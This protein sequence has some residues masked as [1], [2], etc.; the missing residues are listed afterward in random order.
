MDNI[1]TLRYDKPDFLLSVSYQALNI[2]SKNNGLRR[3]MQIAFRLGT[4]LTV[5]TLIGALLGYS[6]D[7]LFDTRP[8][9]LAGGVILGGAAGCLNVYRMAMLLTI[10][11][12]N[13]S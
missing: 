1:K 2:M 12:D 4:E 3:G 7:R 13:N 8:W 9:C 11:D 6:L 10:E 5:A